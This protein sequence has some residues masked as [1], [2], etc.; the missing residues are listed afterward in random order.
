MVYV[1]T[2]VSMASVERKPFGTVDASN[3][4]FQILVEW[5]TI[6]VWPFSVS[7]HHLLY[8]SIPQE[9]PQHYLLGML[10]HFM[11]HATKQQ[12]FCFVS[13]KQGSE[14]SYHFWFLGF[15]LPTLSTTCISPLGKMAIAPH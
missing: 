5:V 3:T 2:K 15:V 10:Q 13:S 11:T 14:R 8:S 4:S 12:F 9:V 7:R 6:S 1:Y